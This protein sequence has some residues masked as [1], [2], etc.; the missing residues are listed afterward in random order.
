[1]AS[2]AKDA[3]R[4]RQRV[5]NVPRPI[6]KMLVQEWQAG[7]VPGASSRLW[8]GMLERYANG[9]AK[10]E[11]ESK[12]KKEWGR[13]RAG[14]GKINSSE[15]CAPGQKVLAWNE[16]NMDARLVWPVSRRKAALD[17]L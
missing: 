15:R 1:L 2:G 3:E 5:H 4:H 7:S 12:I 11:G 6:F 14:R 16:T 9:T 10:T 8:E 13:M 17:S